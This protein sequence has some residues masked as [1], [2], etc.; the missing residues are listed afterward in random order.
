M[1]APINTFITS[2][3]I[4]SRESLHDIISILNWDETP[5]TSI[6]G[7]GEAAVTYEESQLGALGNADA[8][9]SHLGGDDTTA[10]AIAPTARAG[11][12]TQ[13]LKKSFTLSNTQEPVKKA[14]RDSKVSYQTA[15]AGWQ[16]KMDLKAIACQNQASIAQSGAVARKMGGLEGVADVEHPRGLDGG[17][18]TRVASDGWGAETGVLG[19][20]GVAT[21]YEEPKGKA[22]TVIGAVDRY[23][24]DFGTSRRR[25]AATSVAGRSRSSIPRCGGCCGCESRS[26][27]NWPKLE[28]RKFH[29]IGEV[30]LE[31]RNEAGNGI[32][33]DLLLGPQVLCPQN[34]GDPS[35]ASDVLV[36]RVFRYARAT[37]LGSPFG[38]GMTAGLLLACVIAP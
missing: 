32:V 12:R 20:T 16:A 10:A 36:S 17:W 37:V 2:G 24:S 31:S 22:A 34:S 26:L 15:L 29:I 19:L 5:F 18:P 33:T 3:A 23:V 28:T 1:T 7:D 27:R 13:I 9:N 14:G 30:T 35:P 11:N 25:P 8:N 38:V 6:I 21:E 4:G